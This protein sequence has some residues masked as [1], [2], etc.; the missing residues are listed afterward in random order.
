[1]ARAERPGAGAMYDSDSVRRMPGGGGS[2][3]FGATLAASAWPQK[4]ISNVVEITNERFDLRSMGR[5]LRREVGPKGN[6]C[7][8]KRSIAGRVRRGAHEEFGSR[9]G[10]GF[11]GAGHVA[12]GAS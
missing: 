6:K 9:R 1:M 11:A 8:G 5:G 3:G 10:I 12:S 4:A 2:A 7:A